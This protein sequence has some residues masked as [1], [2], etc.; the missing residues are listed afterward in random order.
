[1]SICGIVRNVDALGRIVIPKEMRD[2]LNI[3]IGDPVEITKENNRVML[4]KYVN[5][6]IF[7][8][9]DKD[10][11]EFEEEYVC[12]KCKMALMKR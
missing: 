7:C 9:S 3:N 1:M 12:D 5:G 10:I 4:K 6:C 11:I 8:G 2:L